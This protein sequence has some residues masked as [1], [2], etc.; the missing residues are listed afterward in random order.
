MANY[1][2]P[3]LGNLLYQILPTVYRNRDSGDLK[4][5]LAANG[6][7]LDRVY[8]TLQQ[9]LADNFPDNPNQAGELACQD[10]LL[11]YFAKLLDV[12]LVSP[13]AKGRRD[14]IAHA[15]AWRQRKGTAAV[16]EQIAQAI[17]QTE[18]VMHEGWQRIAMTPRINKPLLP[19]TTYGYSS[20]PPT[21]KP[22]LAAQH[23]DLPAVTVDFRCPS[24]AVATEVGNPAAQ[25]IIID[26][27]MHRWRQVSRHGTPCFPNSF[28]DVSRRT[29]DFRDPTWQHGHFHPRRVL[30]FTPP[31][32]GFFPPQVI[33]INWSTEPDDT[34][35]EHLAIDTSDANMTVYRNKTLGSE[36][37]VPVR[38]AQTVELKPVAVADPQAYTWRFEGVIFNDTVKVHNGRLELEQCAVRQVEIPSIDTDQPV[39][40]A[41]SC[42]FEAIQVANGLSQ[43]E[44]CTVLTDTHSAAIN[45]SD[46]IFLGMIHQAQLPTTP[47]DQGCIR[48]SRIAP[49]QA[50]GGLSLHQVTTKSVIMFETQFGQRSCGVLHP[51]TSQA[52]TAGAEDGGEMG[53]YHHNYYSLMNTAMLD[54]LKDFMPIGI[55]AALIPDN[56]LL[57]T[58]LNM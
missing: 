17:A 22:A 42:L 48:F 50:L 57:E 7:I 55:T 30:L 46:C 45:A 20:E 53:A 19:A 58:P 40:A 2:E 43:L 33:S 25:S 16:I 35:K 44:Y 21:D 37:F 32:A 8:A 29:V 15:I 56:R 39:L 36:N 26:G 38:I 6:E 28:E 54:K 9:R 27:V 4:K 1:K 24:R 18:V 5:Y 14:E 11:P 41:Q 51:E 23:P 47:P 3:S 12:R 34:F 10:W 31:P 52:I 49:E 13:L